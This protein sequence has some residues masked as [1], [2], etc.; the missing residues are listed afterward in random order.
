MIAPEL[1]TGISIRDAIFDDDA[2]C[3]RNNPVGIVTPAGGHIG[4]VRTEILAT[5]LA[6]VLRVGD[7]EFLGSPRN[8][9]TDIE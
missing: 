5:R 9:V 8:Q 4:Q 6:V 3:Q 7:V 1:P 2:E